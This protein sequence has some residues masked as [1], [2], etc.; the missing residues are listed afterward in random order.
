M[1]PPGTIAGRE[2]ETRESCAAA[3]AGAPSTPASTMT[4]ADERAGSDFKKARKLCFMSVSRLFAGYRPAGA[5]PRLGYRPMQSAALVPG[6]THAK[7]TGAKLECTNEKG[8]SSF[9]A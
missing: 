2:G 4:K 8:H 7:P 9:L 1:I 6:V 5:V 3:T